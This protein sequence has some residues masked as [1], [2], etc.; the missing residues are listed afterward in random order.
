MCTAAL[1][2][3]PVLQLGVR[4]GQRIAGALTDR[5]DRAGRHAHAEEVACELDDP[6]SR[7]PVASGQGHHGRLKVHAER[8]AAD[9]H[10]Q[11]G[12]GLG[13]AG[14]AAQPMRA[15]LD[16]DHVHRRQLRDLMTPEPIRRPAL[17]GSELAPAA[18]AGIR[19]VID[20][21]IEPILRCE[22]SA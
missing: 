8:R 5:V 7:D 12:G 19:I 21:L 16:H 17:V 22:L 13:T 6:P 2:E 20:D 3:Q 4:A 10:R 15:M 1:I 14:R 9:R 11:R 18:V